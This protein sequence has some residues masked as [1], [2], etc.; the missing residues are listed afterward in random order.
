[1]DRWR[2]PRV[3]SCAHLNVAFLLRAAAHAFPEH[4]RLLDDM[5]AHAGALADSRTLCMVGSGALYPG[6]WRS[7]AI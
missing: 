3:L 2:G 1:M 6:F 5:R 7:P 4:H